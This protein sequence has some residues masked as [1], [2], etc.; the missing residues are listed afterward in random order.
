MLFSDLMGFTTL[1]EKLPP[2]EVVAMLNEYFKEMADIIFRW[3]GTLDKFVGDGLW[4]SGARLLT[5]QI[6][7]S[8]L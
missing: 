4:Y 7:Q 6:T 8:L 1:S 3:D 5:N 2:E